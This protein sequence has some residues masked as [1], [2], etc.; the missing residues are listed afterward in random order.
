[1]FGWYDLMSKFKGFVKAVICI[2]CCFACLLCVGPV[3]AVSSSLI[4][5]TVNTVGQSPELSLQNLAAVS[6]GHLVSQ[7]RYSAYSG[8]TVIGCLENGTKLTVLGTV[9]SFYKIDCYDMT[10]Y[11]AQTQVAQNEAG[12]YYVNCKADS[13]ESKYLPSYSAQ[14]AMDL[15]SALLSASKDYIGVPY[16]WGGTSSRGFDCSGYTSYLYNLIGAKIN[17]TAI[18]QLSNG[19]IVAKEDMQPGDLV[20]FSGTGG[21]GF[22]SHVGLYIGNGQMIHSGSSKGV[23]I[24]ELS[25]SYFTKYYQ[26]ARRVILTDVSVAVSIPT[27]DTIASGVGSD[28]R[29]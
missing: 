25:N 20:F 22:A 28:W 23:C 3:G 21:G 15:K 6:Q 9:N 7:V 14:E 11:I 26:C 13:S 1:M 12:E 17:R 8:S 10:G 19:V 4:S 24:V 18:S 5:G 2:V 27:M 29:N 16:V